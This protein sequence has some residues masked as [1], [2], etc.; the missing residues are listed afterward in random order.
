MDLAPDVSNIP[1]WYVVGGSSTDAEGIRC[2]ST[3]YG[4]QV[5]WRRD[6][7]TMASFWIFSIQLLLLISVA[8]ASHF[9]AGTVRVVP[10]EKQLNGYLKLSLDK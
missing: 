7:G 2:F 9:T 10:K 8:S 6:S 5:L 1:L 3:A 4:T